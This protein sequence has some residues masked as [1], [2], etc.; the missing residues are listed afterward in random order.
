M[1]FLLLSVHKTPAWRGR[2]PDN[3]LFI[4]PLFYVHSHL[5]MKGLLG[6]ENVH[7]KN[8]LLLT[9]FLFKKKTVSVLKL[10]HIFPM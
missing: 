2:Q 10:R 8:Y 9:L 3:L 5:D 4:S 1:S 7:I 6:N